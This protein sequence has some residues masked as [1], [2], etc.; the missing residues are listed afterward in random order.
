MI[1][2]CC[3]YILT[4]QLILTVFDSWSQSKPLIKDFMGINGHSYLFKPELYAK[5]SQLARAYHPY[6][7][8]VKDDLC[9]TLSLP[10]T[11]EKVKDDE[12]LNWSSIY[13]DWQNYG[14]DIDLSIMLDALN[15]HNLDDDES[16][17]YTY[18]DEI[19]LHLGEIVNSIEIGN[20]VPNLTNDEY[21]KV[22][23]VMACAIKNRNPH[24]PVVTA[25]VSTKPDQYEK[26]IDLFQTREEMYDV[27]NAHTYSF[28]EG[29]PT[30][31]RSY[32]EDNKTEY[33]NKVDDLISWR[34]RYAPNKHIWITEF[35]YDAPSKEAIRDNKREKNME[36]WIP[37]TELEQAQW[38]V[39]SFLI[40]SAKD[41]QRAYLYFFNDQD[42][43]SLHESSGI[44]RNYKPKPAFYAV[45]QLYNSLGDYQFEKIVKKKY[46]DIYIYQYISKVQDD[47]L[48][49]RD[50]VWVAWRPTKNGNLKSFSTKSPFGRPDKIEQMM[51]TSK[52][53]SVAWEW[54]PETEKI[55]VEISGS[56]IYIYF[57][58]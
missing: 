3:F 44:T 21:L 52:L 54:E 4:C 22:F 14:Y 47:D 56:P 34:N 55:T 53:Q 20:E 25:A 19:M 17:I 28:K 8:D 35:G 27:I 1:K 6:Y 24:M 43:L 12:V 9:N 26:S 39:R 36:R 50:R 29:Y 5:T 49:C 31:E 18:A 2:T 57:N 58:P 41:V 51:T 16:C 10:F 38:L 45:S 46:E 30:W 7:W 33:L 23:D 37:S 15:N 48:M 40:F 13:C 32:P 42:R 11:I